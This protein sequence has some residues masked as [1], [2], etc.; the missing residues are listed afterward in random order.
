MNPRGAPAILGSHLDN[1]IS[2]FLDDARS[3]GTPL[4]RPPPPEYPESAAMPRH[5]GNRI[6]DQQRGFPIGPQSPE[7]DPKDPIERTNW[8]PASSAPEN[9]QLLEQGEV[10]DHQCGSAHDR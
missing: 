8:R 9:G 1:Q 2:D 10:F 4:S 7:Q 6:N 3:P 5:D